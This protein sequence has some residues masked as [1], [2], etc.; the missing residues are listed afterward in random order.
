MRRRRPTSARLRQP[1]LPAHV[2]RF[3][4]SSLA[5]STL[6]TALSTF[7]SMVSELKG[8]TAKTGLLADRS[9]VIGASDGVFDAV[10]AQAELRKVLGAGQ[11]RG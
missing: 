6:A 3:A 1:A 10:W 9:I 5:Q 8:R 4:C 2:S 11:G 7:P